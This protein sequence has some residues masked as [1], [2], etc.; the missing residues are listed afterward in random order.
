MRHAKQTLVLVLAVLAVVSLI[1]VGFVF[2]QVEQEKVR[3]QDDIEYRSSLLAGSLKDPIESNFTNRSDRYFQGVVEK[4]VDDQRIAGLMILDSTGKP[5][6]A[7]SNLPQDMAASG[8]IAADAMDESRANGDFVGSGDQ[9]LYVFAEPLREDQAVVGALVIVQNASYIDRYV[10]DIWQRNVVRLL[11]QASLFAVAI[12]VIMRWMV[13]RPLQSLLSV[14]QLSR[15]GKGQRVVGRATSPL[16][17]PVMREFSS[18]QKRLTRAQAAAQ[19]EARSSLEKLDSPWTAE[20]LREFTKGLLK[21]RA[22]VTVSNREPYVHT[23]QGNKISYFVPASGVVTALE[24]IMAACG[25]TWIAHGSGDADRL[26]VDKEDKIAVPPDDPSYTL[27]RVWLS[28]REVDGHYVGFSNGAV[29]PLCHMV[30]TRPTFKQGDWEEYRAVNEKFAKAVLSEIKGQKSPIIIIQDYHFALLPGLIKS[31]R[32]DAAVCIFWHI[33]WPTAEAFSICPW[34]KE[35]LEG[36]LG[37]DIIGFHTQLFCNNFIQTVGKELEA[38]VDLEQF[39]VTKNAHTS[40]V[41]TYPIS[42]DFTGSP[43]SKAEQKTRVEDSAE[44][45]EKLG[46]KTPFVA[47]GV[48]RLDYTKGL[49]ERMKAI[50]L[51]LEKYPAYV[52]KFT[53]IQ[54]AAPSRTSVKEYQQ[55]EEQVI[56]EVERI[57]NSFRQGSWKP[58]LLINEHRDHEFIGRLYRAANVCMVTPLHDGMNLVAKE[59][60]AARSDEKGVLILSQYAGA[61]QEL[62]DALIINPYDGQQ[63]AETIHTAL[64]MT[65]SEQGKRMRKMRNAV[66]SHNVYRWSAEMLKKLAELE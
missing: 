7:S 29:W 15:G 46:V 41:K 49:L 20:R 8:R 4:Y 66:K 31:A 36:L 26:V 34:K 47:V 58:I 48:E 3:L 30:H 52:G 14:M 33:P 38:L 57:N 54:I 64:Q 17:E 18:I 60:V 6:A 56:A 42:I 11:V 53:L 22:I 10:T 19:D 25:G 9:K 62:R 44:L 12:L 16:F 40:F 28:K 63:A 59:F 13:V 51:F 55:F 24:P 35:M 45:L 1:T 21:N 61:A 65:P 32:P 23:K 5:V 43:I 2:N 27:K 39:S 50:E 37:A